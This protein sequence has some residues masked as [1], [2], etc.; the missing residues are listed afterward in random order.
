MWDGNAVSECHTYTTTQ[1][2]TAT[3]RLVVSYGR[4]HNS[5]FLFV[6]GEVMLG[7]VAS[8]YFNAFHEC[9]HNTGALAHALTLVD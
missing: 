8:F 6:L 5:W 4:V 7:V 3:C 9:I 1:D 2:M